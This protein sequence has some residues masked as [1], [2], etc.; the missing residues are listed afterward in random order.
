M[1]EETARLKGCVCEKGP[2]WGALFSSCLGPSVQRPHSTSSPV[3]VAPVWSLAHCPCRDLGPPT[4]GAHPIFL[5]LLP[6][7]LA[8]PGAPSHGDLGSLS[9]VF[10]PRGPVD[11]SFASGCI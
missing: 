1:G 3:S 4:E 9:L 5:C 10:S 2:S 11:L 7:C 8:K 6:V